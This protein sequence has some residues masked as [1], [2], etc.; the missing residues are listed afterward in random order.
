MTTNKPIFKS[1][2]ALVVLLCGFSFNNYSLA[3]CNIQITEIMLNPSNP[4]D[5]WVEIHNYGNTSVN[6]RNWALFDENEDLIATITRGGNP[7]STISLPAGTYFIIYNPA[8]PNAAIYQT[9]NQQN[10]VS[11]FT[12][13]WSGSI[14]NGLELYLSTNNTAPINP[15]DIDWNMGGAIATV[16][17]P[18]GFSG[19]LLNGSYTCFNQSQQDGIDPAFWSPSVISGGTPG[20]AYRTIKCWGTT[21]NNSLPNSSLLSFEASGA[22]DI[23]NTNIVVNN[24]RVNSG[25]NLSFLNGSTRYIEVNGNVVNDGTLLLESDYLLDQVAGSNLSGSGTYTYRRSV[26]TTPARFQIWSSP[27]NN[28]SLATVFGT[29][30][31]INYCDIFTYDF[32]LQQYK[33]DW[34]NGLNVQ[35]YN[36]NTNASNAV[37]FNSTN[38]I[39]GADGLMDVGRGYFATGRDGGGSSNRTFSSSTYNNGNINVNLAGAA[40]GDWALIGNPYP[41]GLSAA[42]FVNQNGAIRTALYFWQQSVDWNGN[43]LSDYKVWTN[44]GGGIGTFYNGAEKV[45]STTY[46]GLHVA[47]TQGFFVEMNGTGNSISFTNNQRSNTV[48][49]FYKRDSESDKLPKAW[50]H[51]EKD[52]IGDNILVGIADDALLERDDYDARKL[53]PMKPPVE[54]SNFELDQNWDRIFFYT[55]EANPAMK[56]IVQAIPTQDAA[57]GYTMP[58]GFH[59][60]QKGI[61]TIAVDST[62][63]IKNSDIVLI[64]HERNIEHKLNKP[65]S[66]E[67]N[68]IGENESRFSLRFDVSPFITGVENPF[69][70]DNVEI[71]Q[72]FDDVVLR[73]IGTN[74]QE[75]SVTD[76][77]GRQVYHRTINNRNEMRIS[78]EN[79]DHGMMIVTLSLEDGNR[80]SKKLFIK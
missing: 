51:L 41:G 12:I 70:N 69:T 11:V 54:E 28:A 35:C 44:L 72:S 9:I 3:Q 29:P 42:E 1:I 7:L 45:L 34:A 57:N 30:G 40:N 55:K 23:T 78:K 15:I 4:N 62:Y 27:V 66:F 13:T 10:G 20:S 73:T 25:A 60:N 75:V 61:H 76:L 37:T 19:E 58:L 32:G 6:I 14:I 39:T 48:S 65:Y 36:F 38:S 21:C 47:P 67:V 80:I 18:V 71:Y 49:A 17:S 16:N 8:S 53:F 22:V 26:S 59:A 31:V 52:G 43:I 24:I 46:V 68:E 63:I 33:H 64:D 74:M 77:A 2:L 50:L 5:Q 79:F 56:Y